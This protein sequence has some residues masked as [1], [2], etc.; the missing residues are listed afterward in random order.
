MTVGSNY[1]TVITLVCVLNDGSANHWKSVCTN[2][3]N[4]EVSNGLYCSEEEV[5]VHSVL[6]LGPVTA[7]KTGR[8]IVI[9]WC[10]RQYYFTAAGMWNSNY[11][12]TSKL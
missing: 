12:D 9:H 7:E 3:L 2:Y 5:V 1:W 4:A 6:K 8:V 10:C 11:K